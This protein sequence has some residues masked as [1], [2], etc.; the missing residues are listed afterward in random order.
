MTGGCIDL[1]NG[2]LLASPAPATPVTSTYTQPTLNCTTIPSPPQSAVLSP[3]QDLTSHLSKHRKTISGLR[4][5]P[6]TSSTAD[7]SATPIKR[8]IRQF[9]CETRFP[10]RK[11]PRT[12]G[13]PPVLEPTSADKLIA[14]IWKQVFSPVKLNCL[15]SV[16]RAVSTLCLKYYN[17][18]QSMRAMEMIV[19]A[20]WIS[21]YESRISSIGQAN[22]HLPAVEIRMTALREA[23]SVLQWKEKDL[24]NRM[25]IWRGYKEIKDSGGWASLIFS[26]AGVYRFCKYRTGFTPTFSTQ[27]RRLRPSI[28]VAADTLHP[29][30]RELLLVIGETSPRIYHGHPH[31]WVITPGGAPAVPLADTYAHLAEFQ[32]EFIDECIIDAAVFGSEDPRRVE[33]V[34]P[35]VCGVCGERQADE[36]ERNRC[37]CFPGLFGCVKTPAPVQVFHTPGKNNGV[38]ARLVC[39]CLCFFSLTPPSPNF[40]QPLPRGTALFPF[41]GLL[42]RGV[43]GRDVMLAGSPTGQSY[44]IL[45]SPHLNISRFINHSCRPNSQFQR[46][47]WRGLEQII[48]VSKGISA[49]SEITVDYSDGYWAELD[50]ECRCGEGACRFRRG[51]EGVRVG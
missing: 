11:K 14:G 25:A 28:E 44:Q 15:V 17:Q 48:V 12:D 7:S 16:F 51:K 45:Q 34:D 27:L 37:L 40:P 2:Q 47:V 31:E 23:C 1:Q 42:T 36:V 19:Q 43:T 18:S 8:Q 13:A 5:A 46:F 33:G 9:H 22:P 32:Y 26:S 50:L 20:H 29:E 30:W 6:S 41:L 49:G 10:Q 39:I 35:D 4:L 21:C 38:V 3:R 24:R